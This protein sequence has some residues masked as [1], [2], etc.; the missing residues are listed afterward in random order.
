[1]PAILRKALL[2]RSTIDISSSSS[3]SSSPPSSSSSF[4]SSSSSSSVDDDKQ[5]ISLEKD[6][7]NQ[8]EKDQTGTSLEDLSLLEAAEVEIIILIII[9]DIS[10]AIIMTFI[11]INIIMMMM[12]T[13]RWPSGVTLLSMTSSQET[14][15]G[16]PV[17]R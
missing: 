6:R 5:T 17:C 11:I 14:M 10:S 4:S 13:T 1:M 2:A 16:S 3:S 15:T 8:F 7:L 12:M 9:H